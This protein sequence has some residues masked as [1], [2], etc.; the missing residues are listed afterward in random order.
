[1][2]V[3]IYLLFVPNITQCLFLYKFN[4]WT[5]AYTSV[6]DKCHLII[7]DEKGLI[8]QCSKRAIRSRLSGVIN[9]NRSQAII[10]S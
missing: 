6:V 7:I 3:I 8:D 2:I 1:M 5:I 9:N 10:N 4:G